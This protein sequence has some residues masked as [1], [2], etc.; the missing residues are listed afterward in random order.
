MPRS[1]ALTSAAPHARTARMDNQPRKDGDPAGA[2]SYD[3]ASG[4]A[5]WKRRGESPDCA[6]DHEVIQE[7]LKVIDELAAYRTTSL[8][9]LVGDDL[10][11]A[12]EP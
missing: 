11:D 6:A 9:L 7:Y 10:G 5:E 3:W 12:Q 2:R 1:V 8:T 4:L